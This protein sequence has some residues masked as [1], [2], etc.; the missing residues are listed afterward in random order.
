MQPMQISGP[1]ATAE[2]WI[3]LFGPPGPG[4]L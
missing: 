1:A 3:R 2:E 4:G